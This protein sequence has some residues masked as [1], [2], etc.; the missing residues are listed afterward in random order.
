MFSIRIVWI[1]ALSFF[2]LQVYIFLAPYC[3]IDGN[4]TNYKATYLCYMYEVVL[5]IDHLEFALI[6]QITTFNMAQFSCYSWM[7]SCALYITGV[8]SFRCSHSLGTWWRHQMDTFSVL[9]ALCT[10]NSPVTGEV[11]SQGQVT[12]SLDFFI[13]TLTHNQV[14]NRSPVIWNHIELIMTLL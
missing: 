7:N 12:R 14:N 13:C 2:H 1:Q 10:G 9:L 3:T 6:D 8:H 4:S 5:T 11:S